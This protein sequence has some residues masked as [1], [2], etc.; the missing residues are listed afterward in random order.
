[1]RSSIENKTKINSRKHSKQGHPN[2]VNFYTDTMNSLM[3]GNKKPTP[4]YPYQGRTL[5]VLFFYGD[6]YK[7]QKVSTILDNFF[8]LIFNWFNLWI[9]VGAAVLCTIRRKMALG[10]NG[11]ISC[12]ID[13]LIA[14]IGGGNLQINRDRVEKWF[15]GIVFV[16]SIFLTA[17]GLESS[18]ISSII[19]FDHKVRTFDDLMKINPP[20]Y[21]SLVLKGN[22][23]V[24]DDMM[25]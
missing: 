6:N 12:Y 17:I 13:V 10:R 7:R 8:S 23:G 21:S 1:M 9:L 19:D 15:F 4:L 24:I 18:L 20:F 16:A 25:K 2:V 14:Y 22:L 3:K 11:L 5:K